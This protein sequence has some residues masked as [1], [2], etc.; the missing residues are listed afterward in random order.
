MRKL[1]RAAGSR[2]A[3]LLPARARAGG[4]RGCGAGN[5]SRFRQ[6]FC[7]GNCFFSV[8]PTLCWDRGQERP[9]GRRHERMALGSILAQEFYLSNP[10]VQRAA[11]GQAAA[12]EDVGVGQRGRWSWLFSFVRTVGSRFGLWART[13]SMGRLEWFCIL[14]PAAIAV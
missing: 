14:P 10:C 4:A 8:R 9:E 6:L 3:A 13:E 12:V 2:G 11:D 1:A 5:G 7:S